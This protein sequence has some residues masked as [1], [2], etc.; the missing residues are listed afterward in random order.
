VLLGPTLTPEAQRERLREASRQLEALVLKQVV[1]A[2]GAFTGGESPGSHIRAGLFAQ[3]LADAMV[4]GGGTGLAAL[5]ERSLGGTP[6]AWR[7][8]PPPG[9]PGIGVTPPA[10]SAANVT[11]EPAA[12]GPR[13]TSPF[14]MRADPFTGRPAPHGGVDLAAPE[15]SDVRAAAGGVVR[16]AGS[17]GGYGNAVEIDHGGGV[18]TLYAHASELLVQEGEAV[19]PGQLIARVGQTGRATGAHLHFE[20]RSAGRPVDPGRALKNYGRRVDE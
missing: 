9:S 18:T 6:E 2:S 12:P 1:V 3:T 4:K 16:S 10:T 19:R 20:V 7:P 11:P 17:R 5:I 15:G 14:G 13:V 8:P